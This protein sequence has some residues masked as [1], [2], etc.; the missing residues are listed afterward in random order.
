MP[1]LSTLAKIAPIPPS[2]EAVPED[3][4]TM[5]EYCLSDRGNA[6]TGSEVRTSLR[7][8]KAVIAAGGKVP[9]L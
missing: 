1:S 8:W 7:T 6:T 3:T 5:S 9:P 2:D 4:S